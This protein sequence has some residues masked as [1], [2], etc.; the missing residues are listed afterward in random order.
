[1]ASVKRMTEQSK[2]LKPRKGRRKEIIRKN[3]KRHIKSYQ[4]KEDEQV[5]IGSSNKSIRGHPKNSATTSFKTKNQVIL[6]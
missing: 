4:Y 6:V 3:L 2:T 1:M 5:V